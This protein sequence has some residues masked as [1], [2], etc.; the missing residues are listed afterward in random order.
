MRV[1]VPATDALAG[2]ISMRRLRQ[3]N[4]AGEQI[5]KLG[6]LRAAESKV[7]F[8]VERVELVVYTLCGNFRLKQFVL[9]AELVLRFLNALEDR[10]RT[11]L[12]SS[13][14]AISYAV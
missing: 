8:A 3:L 7:D 13:H 4:Q 6:A 12:N 9:R 14:V 1:A 5:T 10:K 11:R 2:C